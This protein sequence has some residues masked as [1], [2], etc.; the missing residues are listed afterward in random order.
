V[1]AERLQVREPERIVSTDSFADKD[2]NVVEPSV[3]GM[4]DW[5]KEALITAARAVTRAGANPSIGSPAT[6]RRPEMGTK[7]EALAKQFEAKAQDALATLEQ[8]SDT[9][10]K[11]VTA[12]EKWPVGVTAHHMAGV[13][14]VLPN[15]VAAIV[16]GQPLDGF[17]FDKMDEFNAQHAKDYANCTKAETV[18][19]Y[20]N[21]VAASAAA[22]RA[23]NDNDLAKS[24]TL[25]RGAPSMTAE[26]V[27]AG[28]LLHHIDEHFG[29]IRKTIGHKEPQR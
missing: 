25:V 24:G 3:Y 16:A 18:E 1:G 10:W 7:T 19:L 28:G 26:Q 4:K 15:V 6:W 29:S 2:G 14:H 17:G 20:K 8:L 9:D 5:P 27:I 13:F 12:A 21:G 11:K 23:L 22:I